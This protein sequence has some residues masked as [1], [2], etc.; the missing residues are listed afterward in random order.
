MRYSQDPEVLK[1]LHAEQDY[2]EETMQHTRPL[3]EQ[4]FQEMK[5]RIKEDD[6]SAPEKDGVFVYYTRFETGKQYPFYC[7]KRASQEGDEEILIDQN[8]LAGEKNF[9][10]IGS[11]AISPEANRLAYSVD[12]DGTEV[13]TL[14]VKD[15]TTGK[16]LPD[17]ITNTFGDVYGH[18]GVEWACDGV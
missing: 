18:Q 3:Q 14:Y 13:C 16:L 5:G 17:A 11:F 9:C 4:L 7:R 2:L 6:A 15:L 1:Y 12:A 10:R 8:A